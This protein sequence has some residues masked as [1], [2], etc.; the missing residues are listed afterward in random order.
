MN[1]EV[2]REVAELKESLEKSQL[3]IQELEMEKQ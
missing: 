2:A 1:K 3:K